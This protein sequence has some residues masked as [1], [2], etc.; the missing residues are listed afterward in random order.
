MTR[1]IHRSLGLKS[2][3][4]KHSSVCIGLVAGSI[5]AFCSNP[6]Q[7]GVLSF[8][9][10]GIKFDTDTEADFLFES[11]QGQY[12]ST[13][14]VYELQSQNFNPLFQETKPFDSQGNDYLGTCGGANS[15]VANCNAKFKF[16]KDV[17]YSFVLSSLGKPTVYSTIA[18]NDL[19]QGFSQQAKFSG[20][21]PFV[22]PLLVAFE[23]RPFLLTDK[24]DFNDF[25]ISVKTD[26]ASVPEPAALAGLALVGGA[27]LA[28]H[29][30]VKQTS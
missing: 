28:T 11:S 25:K 17:E 24:I 29:R 27:I 13:F 8:G 19:S 1:P 18:L 2:M 20:D 14:G 10:N 6:A 22:S 4:L 16:L 5:L 12:Q 15:A 3:R 21:D 30:K 7:A 26:T 23:D 9:N